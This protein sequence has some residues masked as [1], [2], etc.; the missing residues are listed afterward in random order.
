MVGDTLKIQGTDVRL[1]ESLIN[2]KIPEQIVE[3]II[4]DTE[5]KVKSPGINNFEQDKEYAFKVIPKLDQ[6]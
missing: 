1:N 4:S 2:F 3:A 5:L 6:T